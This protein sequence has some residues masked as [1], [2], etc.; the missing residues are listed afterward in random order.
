MTDRGN[1]MTEHD[2]AVADAARHAARLLRAVG[3]LAILTVPGTEP[4]PAPRLL[5]DEQLAQ[6]QDL[7]RAE[8]AERAASAMPASSAPARL[9]AI[10]ARDAA[11]RSTGRIVRTVARAAPH[12]FG[13]AVTLLN[14]RHAL[15]Y[16]AGGGDPAPGWAA[17]ATGETYRRCALAELPDTAVAE[18]VARRLG[19]AADAASAAAGIRT[20]RVMPFPGGACPACRRRSLQVDATLADERYWTVTCISDACRCAGP[21]CGCGQGVRIEGRRHAW[22]HSE[23]DGPD[24][25]RRAI[26]LS[27]RHPIRSA[28]AGHGG[29]AERRRSK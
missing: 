26:T 16:I 12:R 15:D 20:E 11:V 19:E 13:T 22:P 18:H 14:L 21:G 28:A 5:S 9:D 27:R 17:S 4:R 29:W 6:M 3:W 10:A 1:H 2:Y 7:A 24:G 8:S 25:L 23:F